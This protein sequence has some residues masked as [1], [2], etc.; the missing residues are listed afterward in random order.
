MK[1]TELLFLG[2]GAADW[3]YKR[4]GALEGF[5]ALSGIL[6]DGHIMIDCGPGAFV[7]EDRFALSGI[8]NDVDTV[9]MTHSH[10]DHFD[11][12]SVSRLCR[13]SEK[14]ITL[15][16]D[17]VFKDLLPDEKNLTF[18][19]MDARHNDS[20]TVAGYKVTC[21]K[22]NHSTPYRE[23]QPLHYLFE[24]E[25]NLF[26]GF[27]GGWLIAD[28]WSFLMRKHIDVYITDATC[29]DSFECTYNFRNF[30]HNNSVMIDFIFKTMLENKIADENTKIILHHL[31]RTLHPSHN[32][33]CEKVKDKGYIVAYDSMKF[34]F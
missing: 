34:S 16:G 8:Y 6:I 30:S 20:C 13:E 18:V 26:I 32:E 23:E 11:A 9:F 7:Y 19:P 28:T 25:K 12:Q 3:D 29:G 17:A 27:D 33:I 15:Y 21:L 22:A 5:R 14:N 24:G 31:A 4:D 2:T 1:K 10:D